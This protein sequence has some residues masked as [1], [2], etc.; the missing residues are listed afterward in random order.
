MAKTKVKKQPRLLSQ[1][2]GEKCWPSVDKLSP[3][4]EICPIHTDVP[5]YVIAIAQGKFKEALAVIRET[6]PFPSICGRVCHHPC[7]TECNRA[8][9]DE[10]IAIEWLKRFVA[11][12]GLKDGRRPAPVRRTRKERVAIIGSG[13]AGLTAAY[14]LIRQGYGAT[15]LEASPVA[16]GMLTTGIPEFILPRHIVEAEIDYIRALGVDI[17]TSTHVGEGLSLDHLSKL[18]FNAFLLAT[19]AQGSAEL[20]IPGT[21]MKSVYYALPLLRQVNLGQAVP[22]RGKVIII[23]GGGVALDAARTA[24]RLGADEAHVTCLEAR[25]DIP[26]FAWEIEAAKREGI[27]L[28]TSLAPQRFTDRQ[29]GNGRRGIVVE[30]KRVASTQVDADG[31]ISWTLVQGPGAD[32]TMEADSIIVAIGQTTDSSCADGSGVEVSRGGT[33][34]ADPDTLA[35]NVPGVFAAGDA[36]SLR[37]TVTEAI[38]MGHEAATSIHRYL[39]GQDLKKNRKM[40]A[41]EVLKVDP[42]MTS[43]WLTHKDRWSMPSLSPNDAVRTFGEADLGY[44][45]AQAI[46]EAKRCL[47]CRMCV[48]CIFGRGQICFETGLR[49]LK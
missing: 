1:I 21:G 37:G 26:A 3:C 17:K 44:T 23:G 22:L 15:V 34:V 24:R 30:F 5:S 47:N 12:Y 46:E 7:E 27:R 14:D 10:P 45:E 40:P 20:R 36:V 35:T 38:A 16:G 48:N 29:G 42:E 41:R 8:L 13:P 9:V 25:G 39:Q 49:L 4:E 31:R 2:H 6:N 11:D 19:G 28:H 33:F 32:Y 43:H 18:G